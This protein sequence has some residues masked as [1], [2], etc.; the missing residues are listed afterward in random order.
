MN[1]QTLESTETVAVISDVKYYAIDR[2]ED[3]KEVRR[4]IAPPKIEV[5]GNATAQPDVD[6]N[7]FQ[8]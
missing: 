1:D 4:E 7:K 3:G 8:K 6:V 5:E 2:D